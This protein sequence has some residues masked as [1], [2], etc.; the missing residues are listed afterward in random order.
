MALGPEREYCDG[1]G[2]VPTSTL[3]SMNVPSVTFPVLFNRKNSE[4]HR[5]CFLSDVKD[6]K[7]CLNLLQ[8]ILLNSLTGSDNSVNSVHEGIGMLKIHCESPLR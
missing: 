8:K 7:G 4:Y 1:W 6:N 3:L 2:W 5:S